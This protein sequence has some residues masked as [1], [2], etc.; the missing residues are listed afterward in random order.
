MKFSINFLICLFFF[1]TLIIISHQQKLQTKRNENNYS[2]KIKYLKESSKQLNKIPFLNHRLHKRE[3]DP[4][5]EQNCVIR[6]QKVETT[7]GKCVILR[8]GIRGCQTDLHL[9]PE[10]AD[11]MI[12]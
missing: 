7:V 9:D 2:N 8:G 1:L 12:E 3:T 10:S 6:V 5:E 4:M 11:C